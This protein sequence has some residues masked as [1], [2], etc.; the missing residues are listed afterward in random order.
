ML[1]NHIKNCLDLLQM[2]DLFGELPKESYLLCDVLCRLIDGHNTGWKLY[3]SGNEFV[4]KHEHTGTIINPKDVEQK[5]FP[6]LLSCE[7]LN[8]SPSPL[9][10]QVIN[11]IE[12]QTLRKGGDFVQTGFRHKKTGQIFGSGPFHDIN[13][14]PGSTSDEFDVEEYESGFID[15]HGKFW[16]REEAA[17]QI[18]HLNDQHLP[19]HKLQSEEYFNQ[20]VAK[21]E[22]KGAYK[23]NKLISIW[24]ENSTRHV[25]WGQNSANQKWSLINGHIEE[26]QDPQ[27]G[28]ITLLFKQT[29]LKPKEIKHLGVANAG[30]HSATPMY[31]FY[32][33]T[34]G[35]PHNYVL[36]AS[37]NI[38]KFKNVDFGPSKSS[39]QVIID[40]YW[41][42]VS[43]GIPSVIE[44]HLA[45]PYAAL[46]ERVG[47]AITHVVSDIGK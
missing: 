5:D 46:L 4:L 19:P 28:A 24:V 34:D 35:I 37:K 1:P 20:S 29:G 38:E 10:N 3:K 31:M 26:N 12:Q 14:L 41:V 39:E 32:M 2:P 17:E 22:Y 43:K 47:F 11:R 23:H 8:P 42:D 25:L 27:T 33:K 9:A 40:W 7:W 6:N 30:E 21:S 18:Y 15:H 13:I 44:K 16:G 36:R 45:H